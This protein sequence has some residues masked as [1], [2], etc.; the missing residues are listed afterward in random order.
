MNGL[1]TEDF[2]LVTKAR[3]V[4]FRAMNEGGY[5]IG[6]PPNPIAGIPGAKGH[7]FECKDFWGAWQVI[8]CW[9]SQRRGC[10]SAGWTL[11]LLNRS[12][13]WQMTYHGAYP[14]HLLP[15]LRLAL[16]TNYAAQRFLGGRGSPELA[17][18]E[19]GVR[20]VNRTDPAQ[21]FM[22]FSGEEVI[23][24]IPRVTTSTATRLGW[25]RFQ[26]HFMASPV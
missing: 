14:D 8:D 19:L 15:L 20:Y 1:R 17:D 11:I 22:S 3:E 23:E 24:E 18:K 4:F 6:A 7:I 13:V 9:I 12:P 5:A 25:H 16:R 2:P 21:D 10:Q 26:G